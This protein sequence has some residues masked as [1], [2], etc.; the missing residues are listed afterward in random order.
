MGGTSEPIDYVYRGP[1]PTTSGVHSYHYKVYAL[2]ND[3]NAV[4]EKGTNCISSSVH[5][6]PPFF[7]AGH[8]FL[9][10]RSF[11]PMLIIL[12]IGDAKDYPPHIVNAVALRSWVSHHMHLHHTTYDTYTTSSPTPSSFSSPLLSF[13]HYFN[14][15][16]PSQ[17][18]AEAS[19]TVTYCRCGCDDTAVATSCPLAEI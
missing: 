5:Y 7:L 12:S 10:L 18:L 13:Y 4:I 3:L 6:F 8:D 15:C 9:T 2:S 11:P 1:C 14:V 19:M 17:V 16:F